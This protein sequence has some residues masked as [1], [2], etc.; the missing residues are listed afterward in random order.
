M[1]KKS[2]AFTLVELLVAMACASI[3]LFMV[4]STVT[5][6]TK[7]NVKLMQSSYDMAMINNMQDCVVSRSDAMPDKSLA[8]FQEEFSARDGD[9]LFKKGESKLSYG[10]LESIGFAVDDKDFIICTLNLEEMDDYSFIVGVVQ[11]Q[12]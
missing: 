6:V 2:R 5:F 3:A 8:S 11:S 4:F 10:K 7:T 1:K 12:E 9:L